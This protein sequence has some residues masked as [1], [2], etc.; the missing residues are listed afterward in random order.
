MGVTDSVGL[1]RVPSGKAG[2]SATS[3][4]LA[5][6]GQSQA[7]RKGGR[8]PGD[9]CTKN[10]HN[11]TAP[12]PKGGAE[13]RL[14]LPSLVGSASVTFPLFHGNCQGQSGAWRSELL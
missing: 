10:I 7:D 12:W 6:I 11:P 2:G 1:A 5:C 3:S 8:R 13:Q 14:K 9:A 4:R